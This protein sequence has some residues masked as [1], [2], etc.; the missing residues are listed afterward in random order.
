MKSRLIS[1]RFKYVRP[2]RAFRRMPLSEHIDLHVLINFRLWRNLFGSLCRAV[3]RKSFVILSGDC[4]YFNYNNMHI[5]VAVY[6]FFFLFLVCYYTARWVWRISGT[7]SIIKWSDL[8]NVKKHVFRSEI[9]LVRNYYFVYAYS[10][11]MLMWNVGCL[12]LRYTSGISTFNG[13]YLFYS[14]A[15]LPRVFD[16]V[17]SYITVVLFDRSNS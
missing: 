17:G 14:I 16:N 15:C 2:T 9:H 12:R 11:Y 6:I 10:M 3:Q 8:V 1:N 5:V 4:D 7:W 13:T